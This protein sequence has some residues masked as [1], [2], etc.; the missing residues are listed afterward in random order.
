[1]TI[2]KQV[3][4]EDMATYANTPEIWRLSQG[5]IAGMELIQRLP[6]YIR[7]L[8]GEN[9]HLEAMAMGAELLRLKVDR[10]EKEVEGF[11]TGRIAS[12]A[13][14]KKEELKKMYDLERENTLLK[15]REKALM[16]VMGK[17]EQEFCDWNSPNAFVAY[18]GMDKVTPEYIQKWLIKAIEAALRGI[19]YEVVY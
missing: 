17:I 2:N 13:T 15:D 11:V 8:L 19:K 14:F 10:L 18:K 12:V 5:L 1:M 16:E 4:V 9:E 7:Y 3:I 6:D